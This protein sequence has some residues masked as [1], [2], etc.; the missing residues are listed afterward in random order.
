MIFLILLIHV[1]TNIVLDCGIFYHILLNFLDVLLFCMVPKL[2]HV[3]APRAAFFTCGLKL[4]AL[5][6][7]FI[8]VVVVI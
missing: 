7:C 3:E 1:L 8:V 2:N 5:N 6:K 4:L